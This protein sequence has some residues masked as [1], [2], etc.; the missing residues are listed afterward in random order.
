[1]MK[2]ISAVGRMLRLDEFRRED[3]IPRERILDLREELMRA[4]DPGLLEEQR[5]GRW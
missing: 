3:R 4:A 5:D 2:L 1:M